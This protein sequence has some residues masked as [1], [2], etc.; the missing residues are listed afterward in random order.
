MKHK[1]TICLYLCSILIIVVSFPCICC[2]N[3]AKQTY[4][5]AVQ[6]LRKQGFQGIDTALK[7]FE[8]IIEQNQD[9][10]P[11]YLGAADAYLLK[12]EFSEKKDPLWLD[13]AMKYLN[14]AIAKNNYLPKAYFKRAI[15]YLNLRQPEKAVSDLK[16]AML[17]Q[18]AYLDARILY[19]QILLSEKKNKQAR[20]FA[21]S[22]LRHFP[23]NPAPLKYFGDIFLQE[24][25]S[26]DAIDFYK[27]I[28]DY[29]P[30]APYTYFAMGKA[31]QNL[32]KHSL[33]IESFQKA[34]EQKPELDEARFA[35]GNSLSEENK[36]EKAIE[37]FVA[38]LKKFPK[39]IS[40]MNNLAL[41][42]EQTK[43]ITHARLMWLKVKESTDDK[44]YRDRAERHLYKLLSI[45]EEEKTSTEQNSVFQILTEEDYEK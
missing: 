7:R 16:T 4:V 33:A 8:E 44:T 3:A 22:S 13:R 2:P 45:S 24:G 15:G 25:A 41:L 6:A 21:D 27:K 10:I 18:P 28:I 26:E 31:Y 19:L 35:L 30:Q 43:Q 36:T 38:Y 5:N 40:A 42:Y 9:F 20:K 32:E 12:H 37:H 11:A 14:I 1:T 23:Q 34:L 39:D 17:I 29:I